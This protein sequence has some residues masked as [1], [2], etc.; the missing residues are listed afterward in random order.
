MAGIGKI[1]DTI[2]V[3]KDAYGDITSIVR[4]SFEVKGTHAKGRHDKGS[5]AIVLMLQVNA[6]TIYDRRT[7]P[8]SL[9]IVTA[10]VEH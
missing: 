6:E 2:F 7:S 1:N 9:K 4:A 10:A 5:N 8:E 3:V